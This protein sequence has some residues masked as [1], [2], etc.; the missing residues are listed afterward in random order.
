MFSHDADSA[1]FYSRPVFSNNNK[2]KRLIWQFTWL[3][4]CSW[5]PAPLHKWRVF[6][7]KCFGAKIGFGNF[8]Y[9]TCKI[10]APWLLETKEVVTIGP[11]VE[12]YNPAGIYLG[13]HSILSQDVYMCGATHDYNSIEFT[14]LMKKHVVES[15]V[16]ICAKAIVLPGVHCN[17]GSVLAAGS[18]ATKNMDSW[19]VYGGNPAKALKKRHQFLKL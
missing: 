1:D 10:W 2:I 3:I 14:Y 7:L 6:I 4:S 15:Y 5:T 13:H 19:T 12:I 18:I 8:I 9:P 17:E 11:G 16:W